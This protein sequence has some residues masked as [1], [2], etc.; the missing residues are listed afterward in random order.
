MKPTKAE[1]EIPKSA[2]NAVDER[3]KGFCRL[4]GKYL[5]QR[6]SIHHIHFGGDAQGMGGRRNHDLNNLVSLC[7]LPGDNN[8][9]PKAHSNKH[10]WQPLLAEVVA[11]PNNMTVLQLIRWNRRR[12]R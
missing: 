6:R 3:D 11:R 7:W 8:C 10:Y 1:L 4:C 9:H 2:R 5:G 12:D